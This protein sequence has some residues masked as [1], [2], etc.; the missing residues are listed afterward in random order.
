MLNWLCNKCDYLFVYEMRAF[1]IKLRRRRRDGDYMNAMWIEKTY[2][3]RRK[4]A[5]YRLIE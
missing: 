5:C 1:T 4:Y 2:R 3:I